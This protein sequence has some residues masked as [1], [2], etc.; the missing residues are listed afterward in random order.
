[1][2]D[3]Q[4]KRK[5]YDPNT[6]LQAVAAVYNGMTYKNASVKYG[7]PI[8]SIADKKNQKYE[9]GPSFNKR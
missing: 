3:K 9:A 6:L 4:K 7:V 2:P 8:A 5:N 1:M